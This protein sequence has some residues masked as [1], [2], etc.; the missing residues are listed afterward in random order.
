MTDLM[1]GIV[2]GP[3]SNSSAVATPTEPFPEPLTAS[4]SLPNYQDL[5]AVDITQLSKPSAITPSLPISQDSSAKPPSDTQLSEPSAISPSLPNSQDSSAQHSSDIQL[6]EPSAISPSLPI[7]QDL[8]AGP[9]SDTIQLSEPSGTNQDSS[10]ELPSNSPPLT[11]TTTVVSRHIC[12]VEYTH[13]ASLFK[14]MR[15]NHPGHQTTSVKKMPA[16]LHA[17]TLMV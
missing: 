14:H 12:G 11:T 16:P 10:A 5:S 4:P 7:S 3:P 9:P 13:R 6:S 15:K 17:G 8:S 1:N 2:N